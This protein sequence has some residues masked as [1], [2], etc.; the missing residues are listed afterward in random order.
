MKKIIAILI[1]LCVAGALFAADTTVTFK[2]MSALDNRSTGMGGGFVADTSDYFTLM[3]NPAG[4]AFA[5][6]H[7]LVGVT[8]INVGGPFEDA[9][10]IAQN[11]D[12]LSDQTAIIN[13]AKGLLSQNKLNLGF[14]L[15][16]PIAI[17]GTYKNGFGWGLADQVVVNVSAPSTIVKANVE[18]DGDFVLGYGHAFDLGALGKLAAG[19]STDIYAQV[20]YMNVNANLLNVLTATDMMSALTGLMQFKTSMGANINAGIQ[21][22]FLDF[23]N[24]AA[25]YNSMLSI[26]NNS[27][28]QLDLENLD[29][30]ALLS[31]NSTRFQ[32]TGAAGTVDVGV[33]IDIPTKW[34]LGLISDWGAYADIK[35][36]FGCM[37]NNPL[38]RNP[39]LNMNVGTEIT[40]LNFISLRGGISD[41]YLHAG[42]GIRLLGLHLDAAIYGKELGTE[43]G[44]APQ[45]NAAI[46]IGIRH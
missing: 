25:V 29:P 39:I 42:A 46:S 28:L 36:L 26:V 11:P 32:T 19:V 27:P 30:S 35:D 5:G 2:G 41:T 8:N 22:R 20:P 37:A 21:W 44:S 31:F 24:V 1:I 40:L 34:S 13:T 18:L 7:N 15:G 43:P 23:L 17:G 33:G 6:R 45:L 3:R 4:L 9:I 10:A 14:S 16:G 12:M 38:E